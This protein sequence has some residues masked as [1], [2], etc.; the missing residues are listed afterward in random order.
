MDYKLI[1]S[2]EMQEKLRTA[3]SEATD[4]WDLTFHTKDYNEILKISLSRIKQYYPKL[5]ITD[6]EFRE[7]CSLYGQKNFYFSYIIN[8]KEKVVAYLFFIPIN[9]KTRSGVLAQ[10]V[11]PVMS[12]IMESIKKSPDNHITNRPLFI[13]NLNEQNFTPAMA[14]N[15]LCGNILNFHYCDL[16]ERDIF[17]KLTKYEIKR[18]IQNVELLNKLI[19]E[20]SDTKTNEYFRLDERNKIITVLPNKL[21][22]GIAV[23]NEPYWF[24]LKAYAG[25][26]LANK[27]KYKINMSE[28]DILKPGNKTLDSFRDFIKKI[29][30]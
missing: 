24:V 14:L 4:V 9:Y 26:Y 3:S 20:I 11:F 27:Q 2:T 16:Y 22:D 7:D 30:E 8:E 21:N 12:G 25:I 23:T 13:L 15:V 6:Y 29:T 10:Q 18:N 1:L 5:N 28:F 19:I 17:D